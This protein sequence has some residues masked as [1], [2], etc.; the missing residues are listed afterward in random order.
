MSQTMTG[1]KRVLCLRSYSNGYAGFMEDE[2][3]YIYFNFTR[4]GGFKEIMRFPRSDY[5]DYGHFV[6]GITRFFPYNF[7]L[8][9]PVV[10]DACTIEELDRIS[11]NIIS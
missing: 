7:F 2:Q 3:D 4:K 6:G 11:E 8:R 9:P 1:T 5:A 10:I